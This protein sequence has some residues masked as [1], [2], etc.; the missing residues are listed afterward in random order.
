MSYIKIIYILIGEQK[1]EE[2]VLGIIQWIK[3][4]QL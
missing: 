2:V 3:K 4:T 1:I